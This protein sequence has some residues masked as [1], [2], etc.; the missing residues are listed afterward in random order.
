MVKECFLEQIQELYSTVHMET[1]HMLPGSYGNLND[2]SNYPAIPIE[3]C[4]KCKIKVDHCWSSFKI[5]CSF[6]RDFCQDKRISK[7]LR[8]SFHSRTRRFN[9]SISTKA[10]DK[11]LFLGCVDE[12]M[13]DGHTSHMSGKTKLKN[14][15]FDQMLTAGCFTCMSTCTHFN[16]AIPWCNITSMTPQFT[17]NS[18]V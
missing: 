9:K 5:F 1:V 17:L 12:V 3:N 7:R 15:K 16:R 2:D 8:S 18:Q 10:V 11:L 13:I 14:Q 4:S 6:F